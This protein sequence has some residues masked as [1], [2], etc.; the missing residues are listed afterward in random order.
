[1]S[2]TTP[3]DL[4]FDASLT[5]DR[6]TRRLAI[7]FSVVFGALTVLSA[8]D[9]TF[10]IQDKLPLKHELVEDGVLVVGILGLAVTGIWLARSLR[11]ERQLIAQAAV[12]ASRWQKRERELEAESAALAQ[13]L[14]VSELETSRWKRE[15]GGLI[16]GLGAAIDAQFGRWN[17]SP[18]EREVALLLLKGLSH[19]EI[20]TLRRVGEATVRQQAQAVYRKSGLANRSDL[21]AFFLED[22]LLPAHDVESARLEAH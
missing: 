21:A 1:M 9:I 15:A 2:K 11:R 14:Q 3:Y 13:Q 17:L 12:L 22:L 20:G 7:T 6:S 8:F 5:V 10:D 4:D 18:A 16:A 19:K